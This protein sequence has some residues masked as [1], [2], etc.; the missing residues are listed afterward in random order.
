MKRKFGDGPISRLLSA[1]FDL[2]VIN[3]LCVVCSLPVF[4][5]GAAV[6][7]A[8]MAAR[9]VLQDGAAGAVG[10][11][12]SG[13]R[14]NFRQ[15]TF[16][17]LGSVVVA[18][19]LFCYY[20]LLRLYFEGTLYTV[21]LIVLG[22]VAFIFLA[23]LAYAIPLLTRYKNTLREHIHNALILSVLYFPRTLLMVFLHA[24]PFILFFMIPMAFVY[25][26][27]F[28]LML[29]VSVILLVD[30]MLL[31]G[32]FERLEAGELRPR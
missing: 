30:A 20:L 9:A 8:F 21:L 29:G 10:T 31:R 13:F 17:T 28:W 18:A 5:A 6:S 16:L 7:G 12:F 3:L 15:A 23:I 11:F 32:V 2:I 19:A 1:V 24:L 26:L 22:L 25:T 14:E 4:T 27:L